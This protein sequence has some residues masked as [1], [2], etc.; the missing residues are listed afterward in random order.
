MSED[1]KV[2]YK[3]EADDSGL[4][5]QLDQS[6]QTIQTKTSA[7]EKLSSGALNR[8]GS[9]ATDMALKA[10]AA[11]IEYGQQFEQSL[12]NASTLIDTNVTDMDHLKESILDL[13][14]SSGVAADELNNALYSALSAGIPATEDMSEAMSFLESATQLAKAGFTDMD[15]AVS[16]TAKVLNAYGM[17]VSE[18][19]RVHKVLMQTQNLGITTVDQLGSTLAQVTPTA[20]A[21]GVSFEQVG[22]ALATMT[23]KGTET[24]TATAQLNQLL[25]ELGKG[26]TDASDLLRAKTG[27]SFQ[28]L[29]ASGQS[30]SEILKILVSAT[31]DTATQISSMMEQTNSLTGEL[32]T[33][34]EACSA[35][36]VDTETLEANLLDMF[37]S[38]EAGK[39]ALSIAGDETGKFSE[40][41]AAMSTQTD[42]VGEAYDKVTGTSGAK[43]AELLNRLKN[44]AIE[45]FQ[46]F[47]PVLEEALPL[48]AD[49]LE[50]V[51]PL[52][53]TVSELAAM[54]A[55]VL[56]GALK[57]A[58]E[59]LSPIIEGFRGVVQ[60]LVDFINGITS[61]NWKLA[62]QGFTGIVKGALSGL[63]SIV[64]NPI[65]NIIDNL[66]KFISSV[67]KIK[68]PDW[69]PGVGGKG[70]NLPKIPRLQ[71]GEDYV[72]EDW[73][74]AFLDRGERVLTAVENQKYMAAGGIEGMER[75][76]SSRIGG[77]VPDM[78]GIMEMLAGIRADIQAGKVLTVDRQTFAQLVAKANRSQ[79]RATG[80]DISL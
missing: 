70:I 7:W 73:T 22:A 63:A 54:L 8:I 21:M 64:K 80:W 40:N 16:A 19:D 5:K 79:A 58:F 6:Q 4:D 2:V 37:G 23:A 38:L 44:A 74:P 59:D 32:Y 50:Q 27:K 10:G 47:G 53:K 66:N 77:A 65:N 56:V 11:V 71:K 52:I 13:S 1:G 30:L 12:A 57:E 49:L 15:T 25:A 14:N 28:E 20:A 75:A 51:A 35:L 36:G 43:F 55:K 61:G 17:D 31:G 67:N 24:S 72:M 60:G 29:T 18:V 48:L 39:A 41:L 69:V 33:Y 76:I 62:W 3:I 9:L 42:V 68:I 45:V 26:G 34:E 78:T 46:S